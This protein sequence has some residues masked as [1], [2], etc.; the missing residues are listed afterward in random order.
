MLFTVKFP[1]QQYIVCRGK[2]YRSEIIGWGGGG[3]GTS[4]FYSVKLCIMLAHMN[5]NEQC[6]GPQVAT[7]VET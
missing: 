3:G 1:V 2:I 4:A 6:A 7:V 5:S